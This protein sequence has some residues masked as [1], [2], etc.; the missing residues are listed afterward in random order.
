MLVPAQVARAIVKSIL[1][2]CCVLSVSL[3]LNY[4]WR[5]LGFRR[6]GAPFLRPSPLLLPLRRATWIPYAFTTSQRSSPSPCTSLNAVILMKCTR[7]V[8]ISFPRWN[9]WKVQDA[10]HHGSDLCSRSFVPCGRQW[11]N[12]R[13]RRLASWVVHKAATVVRFLSAPGLWRSESAVGVFIAG[14]S[15]LASVA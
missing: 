10:K 12:R 6:E 1:L 4:S 15:R 14:S 8:L 5:L 11:R 2:D 7:R 3:L 9:V 13:R